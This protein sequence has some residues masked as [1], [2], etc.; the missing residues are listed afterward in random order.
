[1]PV[2]V[3]ERGAGI[4][5]LRGIV[6]NKLRDGNKTDEKKED[7]RKTGN[8]GE[9]VMF[10]HVTMIS[11]SEF[12]NFFSMTDFPL[13]NIETMAAIVG[14]SRLKNI[15]HYP[16]AARP[17]EIFTIFTPENSGLSS[18]AALILSLA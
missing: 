7:C 15:V 6:G 4:A 14:L 2:G 10:F 11:G 13:Q 5:H 16:L 3:A 8:F 12:T 9:G 1:M 18:Q 17:E